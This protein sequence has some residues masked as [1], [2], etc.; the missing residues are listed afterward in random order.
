MIDITTIQTFPVSPVLSQ[1]ETV[2][3]ALNKKNEQLK[4]SLIIIGVIGSAYFAY[5][6]F[7]KNSEDKQR[8]ENELP[9]D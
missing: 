4:I 9:K 7:K 5:I 3:S 1:L 2:N 8:T 6:I